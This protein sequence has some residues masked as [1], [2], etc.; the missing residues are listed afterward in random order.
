[1]DKATSEYRRKILKRL[2]PWCAAV[3]V[4]CL[5]IS[6]ARGGASLSRPGGPTYPYFPEL[7]TGLNWCIMVLGC[8]MG[9]IA[10]R[11]GKRIVCVAFVA[12]AVLWNP[13][14]PIYADRGNWPVVDILTI[15]LFLMGPGDLWPKD[16]DGNR[17]PFE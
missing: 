14:M 10:H 16:A 5:L 13:L 8:V 17:L 11:W 2:I 6:P 12:A 7:T 1:M 9:A 15:W 3:A 4:Y